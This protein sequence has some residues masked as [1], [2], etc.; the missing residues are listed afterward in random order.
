LKNID[1]EIRK[2]YELAM[3]EIQ[4]L[5][6]EIN[7][8]EAKIAKFKAYMLAAGMI[9]APAKKAATGGKRGRPK[10]W[11]KKKGDETSET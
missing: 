7:E 10:G 5:Q 1:E 8:K 11:K 4:A 9:E 3:A 6:Q 2:E